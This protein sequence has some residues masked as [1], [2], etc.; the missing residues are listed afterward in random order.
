MRTLLLTFGILWASL[1]EAGGLLVIA[2]PQVPVEAISIKQLADIYALKK[3]RWSDQTQVVPVNREATGIERENFSEKVFSLSPQELS[4]FWNKLRFQGKQ[5]P[6]I[7]SS[8]M[9]VLAFVRNIPGAIGYISANSQPTG[10][11]V[12]LRLP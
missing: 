6:V 4:D 11:K 3:T 7:Q 2:S 12:L 9:A 10:V 1:S 8:D 5:P